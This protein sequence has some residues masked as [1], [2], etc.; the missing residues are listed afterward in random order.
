ML[1]VIPDTVTSVGSIIF[2]NCPDEMVVYANKG[3]VAA[4]HCE[5]DELIDG[6]YLRNWDGSIWEQV[7]GEAEEEAEEETEDDGSFFD[8]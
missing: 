6:E 4:V 7:G 5:E 2:D 1:V 3:T 8:Q